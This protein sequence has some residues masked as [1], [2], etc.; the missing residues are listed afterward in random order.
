MEYK[1]FSLHSSD[2]GEW[3]DV[4][5][6]RLEMC[7]LQSFES[8][9]EWIHH[10]EKQHGL[11]QLIA[12]GEL[13]TCKCSKGSESWNYHHSSSL[14][15]TRH[16]CMQYISIVGKHLGRGYKSSQQLYIKWHLCHY[17]LIH[18]FPRKCFTCIS[19]FKVSLFIFLVYILCHF[20]C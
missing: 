19:S 15:K 12:G 11:K 14:A 1:P 10:S 18:L 5:H 17:T 7:D 9:S 16:E 20:K 13:P 2:L 4:T 8:S 6:V 3:A